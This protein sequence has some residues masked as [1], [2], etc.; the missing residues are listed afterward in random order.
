MGMATATDESRNEIARQENI[1][2]SDIGIIWLNSEDERVC[3]VCLYLAGRWFD[4]HEAYDIAS[5]VHGGSNTC[6]CPP[7]FDVGVPR[8]AL[9]GP[10]PDYKPGTSADVLSGLAQTRIN[11]SRNIV[12]R[13][14]PAEYARPL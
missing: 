4:A 9:V 5:K 11:L 8:E 7:H 14:K 10:I 3:K 12:A 6:R 1:P 2:A 13:G